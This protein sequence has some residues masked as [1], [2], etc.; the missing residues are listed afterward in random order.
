MRKIL[1]SLFWA[2]IFIGLA[3]DNGPNVIDSEAAKVIEGRITNV[4][5][6]SSYYGPNEPELEGIVWNGFPTPSN[7]GN[8]AYN[9][10]DEFVGNHADTTY[11]NDTTGDGAITKVV[12]S[13]YEV[14]PT[15]VWIVGGIGGNGKTDKEGYCMLEFPPPVGKSESDYKN[16]KFRYDFDYHEAFLNHFDTL[17]IKVFLQVEAGMANMDTLV[18]LVMRQYKHHES[19]I[20]FGADIEWYPSPLDANGNYVGDT[21][22]MTE[23]WETAV[24]NSYVNITSDEIAHIDSL[25]KNYNPE[26]RIFV[27]HWEERNCGN[28]PVS[29]VV[30]INDAQGMSFNSLVTDFARWAD[31]FSPNDV[32]FQI[33]YGNDYDWWIK[34][35]NP[36]QDIGEAIFNEIHKR[37]SKQNVHMYWVDFSLHYQILGLYEDHP[38]AK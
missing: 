20:G 4:G 29:D 10:V 21:S 24:T 17:G 9:I 26:Y 36:I 27:K 2:I 12:D 13:I 6:R 37:N 23:E 11:K 5:S 8:I 32:G 15:M 34:L 28:E 18:H 22:A 3:C 16:I 33:G 30:Y 35:N 38:K 25:V 19:V 31:I 7:W 1:A 14:V